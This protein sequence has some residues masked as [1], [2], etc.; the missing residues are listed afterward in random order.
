MTR[1]QLIV[2][3]LCFSGYSFADQLSP[4]DEPES[5]SYAAGGYDSNHHFLGGTEILNLVGH[6]GKLYAGVGYWMDRPRL[7]ARDGQADPRSSAQIIVLDKKSGAWRHEFAFDLQFGR[8]S[9]MGVVRFHNYDANGKRLDT[10]KEMLIAGLEGQK[11]GA[12]YIQNAPGHWV[13]TQSP[14]KLPVRAFAVH[15]DPVGKVDRLYVGTGVGETGETAGAIYSGVYDPIAEGEIRWNETPDF[16]GFLNRAMTMV[17]CEGALYF[18]AKP[19]IYRLNDQNQTWETLY[20]SQMSAF[21]ASKYASGFRG[22]TCVDDPDG[23]GHKVLLAAFEGDSS[24]V[25]R[26]NPS[27]GS[28]VTEVDLRQFLTQKWG[29]AL[30]KPDILTAYNDMPLIDLPSGPTYFLSLL[31]YTP[32][33]AM[34]N[35]AFFLTRSSGRSPIYKLHEVKPLTFPYSRSDGSLYST[36]TIAVSP[37]PEDHGQVIYLGGYDGHFKPDHNTAWIYR[38]GVN[39]ATR[40]GSE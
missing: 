30:T 31:A 16:T 39:T 35:S 28:A 33:A 29:G 13:D 2:V 17:E 24:R 4:A 27:D 21:D 14:A 18:A 5:I 40:G 19:S 25:L 8:L 37:F 23:S 11:H 7:F 10:E 38:E 20:T 9:A 12:V 34:E 3:L 15:Y 22:L 36:R 26:I 32:V 6:H 1:F